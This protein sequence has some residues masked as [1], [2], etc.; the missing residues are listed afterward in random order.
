MSWS[1]REKDVLETFDRA[2]LDL[3]DCNLDDLDD[4]SK[5]LFLT[6]LLPV[7]GIGWGG[8]ND[9]SV[10]IDRSQQ[11]ENLL[12]DNMSI[13][14]NPLAEIAMQDIV[15]ADSARAIQTPFNTSFD[16]ES[17]ANF[18]VMGSSS[19][20]AFYYSE[21]CKDLTIEDDTSQPPNDLTPG[22]K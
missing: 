19:S 21:E 16:I 12:S 22:R 14:N 17:I 6:L 15:N 7:Y 10:I 18:Y 11:R 3:I 2:N 20:L 1:T 13:P 8:T 4:D 9:L 5:Y